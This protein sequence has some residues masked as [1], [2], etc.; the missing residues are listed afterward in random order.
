M[1]YLVMNRLLVINILKCSQL[2]ELLFIDYMIADYS[3]NDSKL[4]L[5]F[6]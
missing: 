4:F 1:L 5:L 2:D 3:H 6:V